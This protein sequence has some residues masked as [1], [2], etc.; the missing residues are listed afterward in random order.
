MTR[1]D[2]LMGNSRRI[3][4]V[5]LWITVAVAA[6]AQQEK[7]PNGAD[8]RP[9]FKRWQLKPKHQGARNTCSVC[10]VTSAFEYALSR[11]E[12][13]G[14]PLSAEYLNWGCNQVI[15]NTTDDRGQFF[16]DLLKGY[17]QYG[18]CPEEKMPYELK[19]T[20]AQ[21][22]TRSEEHTSELQSQR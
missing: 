11:Q 19:F 14:V 9:N 6:S 5:A 12:D 21:P 8:L 22:S 4:F 13:R 7:Q 18:I 3:I 10:V 16:Y 1:T 15:Q 2:R 20:N 17:E